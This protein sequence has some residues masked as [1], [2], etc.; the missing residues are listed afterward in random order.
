MADL[1]PSRVR[2]RRRQN[3]DSQVARAENLAMIGVLSAARQALVSTGLAPEEEGE[4]QRDPL[5]WMKRFFCRNLRSARRGAA[6]RPS[7][8]TCEHLQPILE[9]DRGHRSLV[10]CL[11]VLRMG[12]F[13][14]LKKPQGG[15]RGIWS[16]MCFGGS[17]PEQSRNCAVAPERAAAPF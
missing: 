8:M 10:P 17:L 2:K 4:L 13:A 3:G 1:R 7:G 11:L 16:A 5:I 15:V 14:A 12:R 6:P 9:S